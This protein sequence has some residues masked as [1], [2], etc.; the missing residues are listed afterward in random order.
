MRSAL[1]FSFACIALT[2]AVA[3]PQGAPFNKQRVTYVNDGLT[4]VGYVYKPNG[5]GPFPTV[6]WNH[7]SEKNPGGGPQ[8]DSVAAIF[9]PAGYAVMAPMRR[10]HSDSQGAWISDTLQALR[11]SGK[12]LIAER[13]MVRVMGDEQPNDP[14]PGL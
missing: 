6:V 9:V 7:G 3:A 14:M 2:A 13:L 10:G 11:R 5:A 8:Y 4:L 12:G 1:P